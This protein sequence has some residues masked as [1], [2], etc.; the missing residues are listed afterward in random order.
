MQ[1]RIEHFL[2]CKE[3]SEEDKLKQ[4]TD[5]FRIDCEKEQEML[6][7]EEQKSAATLTDLRKK[8]MHHSRGRVQAEGRR[9]GST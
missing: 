1:E 3:S 4:E 6:D 8:E 2:S 7:K 5:G 9:I